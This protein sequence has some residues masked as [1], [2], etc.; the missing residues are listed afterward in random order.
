MAPDET[1]PNS[2]APVPVSGEGSGRGLR[3]QTLLQRSTDPLFLLN[4]QSRIVFVNRAWEQATGMA[5]ADARGLR[6]RARGRDDTSAENKLEALCAP[7]AETLAGSSSRARRLWGKVQER[8]CWW[9][10]EFLPWVESDASVLILGRLRK[11]SHE[12]TQDV[13]LPGEADL[14][15]VGPRRQPGFEILASRDPNLGLIEQQARLASSCE[16]P[17]LLV[18][19]RGTGKRTLAEVIHAASSRRHRPLAVLPCRRLPGTCLRTLLSPESVRSMGWSGGTL[20]LENLDA[21][22]LDQQRRLAERIDAGQNPEVRFLAGLE[23]DPAEGYRQDLLVPELVRT[24]GVLVVRVPPLRDRVADLADLVQ[25]FLTRIARWRK[26]E[27]KQVSRDAWLLL[28][29]YTWPGNLHELRE[30]LQFASRHAKTAEIDAADLPSRLR[31]H[32]DA[33]PSA[34]EM[35][36]KPPPLD[37]L[38]EQVERRMIELALKRAG[39]NKSK[40]AEWLGIWRARLIRRV[41]ALGLGEAGTQEAE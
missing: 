3:W 24:L 22:P 16:A 7:P 23:L 33:A 15:R 32:V 41:E 13:A 2:S 11:S 20:Y 1:G 9:E 35:P 21:L 12:P 26:G 38:L 31:T 5:A 8:A 17:V 34:G 19:E 27:R 36:V 10:V 4:R 14:A 28:C 30:V 6:C 25:E 40:A 37:Q 39:G 29:S 18:G